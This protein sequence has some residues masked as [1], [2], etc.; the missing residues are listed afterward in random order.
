M[1]S[2]TIAEKPHACLSFF[3]DDTEA[4]RQTCEFSIRQTTIDPIYLK[5]NASAFVVHNS[6]PQITCVG[7]NSRPVSNSTC[8][9]CMVT[10]GCACV[11][12][13]EET[14]IV[15]PTDCSKTAKTTTTLHSAYNAAVLREFYDL[16]NQSLKGDHLVPVEGLSPRS[17]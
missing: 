1:S 10:I 16:A 13:S 8:I 11:L 14:R 5:L 12:K 3:Y 6:N 17:H 2:C 7:V 4:I 9:P 15:A